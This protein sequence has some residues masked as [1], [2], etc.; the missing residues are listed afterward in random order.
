MQIED[1]MLFILF[2]SASETV[3]FYRNEQQL[4]TC[5]DSPEAL[6]HASSLCRVM[7]CLDI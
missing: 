1:L 5:T 4:S 3:K 7:F 2:E 6:G